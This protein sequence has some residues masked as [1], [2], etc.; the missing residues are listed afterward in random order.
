MASNIKTPDQA[1]LAAHPAKS[2][3]LAAV[4]FGK[5]DASAA[6]DELLASAPANINTQREQKPYPQPSSAAHNGPQ[7]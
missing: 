7:T 6:D 3:T 5:E 2:Q 1:A 4:P